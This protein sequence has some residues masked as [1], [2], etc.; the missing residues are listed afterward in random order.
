MATI[1]VRVGREIKEISGLTKS[2]TCWDVVLALLKEKQQGSEAENFVGANDKTAAGD[3][4]TEES[5]STSSI[6][7]SVKELAQS[8]VIVENWRG[9]E[10][11]IPPRT[12]ILNVWQAW[13][14]EQRHVELSLKKSKHIRFREGNNH[15]SRSRAGKNSEKNGV[16]PEHYS[17]HCMSNHQKRK[18]RRNMRQYQRA[19]MMKKNED[20]EI[21]SEDQQ[22]QNEET[23]IKIESKGE[24]RNGLILS[25]E[26]FIDGFLA[27]PDCLIRRADRAQLIS[28]GTFNREFCKYRRRNRRR[29][30]SSDSRQH[31]RHQVSHYPYSSQHDRPRSSRR[32]MKSKSRKYRY[33]TDETSSSSSNTS[34]D[35]NA[36]DADDEKSVLVDF[37]KSAPRRNHSYNVGLGGSVYSGSGTTTTATDSS[38]TT[39]GDSMTSS[40]GGSTSSETS[41]GGG[42]YFLPELHRYSYN[43]AMENAK[44]TK[45]AENSSS[46]PKKNK[47]ILKPALNLIESFRKTNKRK[48]NKK[49][50]ST[51]DKPNSLETTVTKTIQA[52]NIPNTDENSIKP[53]NGGENKS[54]KT[55][56]TAKAADTE[57]AVKQESPVSKSTSSDKD[58]VEAKCVVEEDGDEHEY[59]DEILQSV[60]SQDIVLKNQLNRLI[61]TD[62]EIELIENDIHSLRTRALGKNYVQ[63]TYLSGFVDPDSNGAMT[64]LFNG[65]SIPVTTSWILNC[66]DTDMLERFT[67]MSEKIV[68]MQLKI[69]EHNRKSEILLQDMQE[70]VWRVSAV[71]EGSNNKRNAATKAAAL[72]LGLSDEEEM[73]DDEDRHGILSVKSWKDG[74]VDSVE[75]DSKSG[76]QTSSDSLHLELETSRT[77]LEASLYL[78]IRLAAEIDEVESKLGTSDY[79]IQ[80]KGEN[81][82]ECV[83][84]LAMSE[85]GVS[86]EIWE[87]YGELLTAYDMEVSHRQ[88]LRDLESRNMAMEETDN[89]LC[90][91]EE[92]NTLYIDA[93]SPNP[94]SHCGNGNSHPLMMQPH[95]SESPAVFVNANAGHFDHPV[96]NHALTPWNQCEHCQMDERYTRIH[97][98]PNPTYMGNCHIPACAQQPRLFSKLPLPTPINSNNYIGQPRTP[99]T[100]TQG[101]LPM[102]PIPGELMSPVN[103]NDSDYEDLPDLTSMGP[104]DPSKS[105]KQRILLD[106]NENSNNTDDSGNASAGSTTS[107]ASSDGSRNSSCDGGSP[108]PIPTVG[109]STPANK[110][111]FGRNGVLRGSWKG[112]FV[113]PN[114]SKQTNYE[115]E[116]LSKPLPPPTA[117]AIGRSKLKKPDPLPKPA[118]L[119]FKKANVIDSKEKEIMMQQQRLI[120]RNSIGKRKN[121]NETISPNSPRELH[122]KT[123]KLKNVS[124]GL[125][126]PTDINGQAWNK[127][128]TKLLALDQ[129]NRLNANYDNDSDTGRSSLHSVDSDQVIFSETLV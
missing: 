106:E 14:K 53:S 59:K 7:K 95:S 65:P 58:K 69:E 111:I 49:N 100:I 88:Y 21:D 51:S 102:L 125:I 77:E 99:S 57:V 123:T 13:G 20:C 4:A 42:D 103:Q 43:T 128:Q 16:D 45:A 120:R 22:N 98:H 104:P 32:G 18:I 76:D 72:M 85:E 75:S 47:S 113:F 73:S 31:R 36:S 62:T 112:H 67:K 81:M 41:S 56:A 48:S 90:W 61:E 118:G 110:Q 50:N 108:R 3:Q 55:D 89:T 10:K 46:K 97:G 117:A 29:H 9:C 126:H 28:Q 38:T 1:A 127:G 52:N 25:E 79:L 115:T 26:K 23:E 122:S 83:R 116:Q 2:T 101:L 80:K 74:G 27:S 94:V 96:I 11:P 40:M 109:D 91:P 60:Q 124:S 34:E 24:K 82:I 71:S 17:L 84:D 39:S 119:T 68:E 54:S 105:S 12:R 70:E 15:Q 8:Y 5:A 86:P 37:T 35:E 6:S 30:G 107:F 33:S 121:G 44:N 78:S 66:E 92:E 64:N 87:E 63:D 19:L 114:T 129:A 93:T